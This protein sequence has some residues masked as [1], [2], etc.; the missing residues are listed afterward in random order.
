MCANYQLLLTCI[1]VKLVILKIK[2]T[3]QGNTQQRYLCAGPTGELFIEVL[4][5]T[6]T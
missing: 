1:V 5:L 2:Q 4:S 3:Y 6:K